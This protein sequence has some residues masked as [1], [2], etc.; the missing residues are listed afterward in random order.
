MDARHLRSRAEHALLGHGQSL[1][2]DYDGSVRPGDDL[3]TSCVL[4]L[5]PD[6]GALKWYFQ[7]SPHDFMTTMPYR[8]LSWWM[9]PSRAA[10]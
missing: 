4:A 3:Y 7:Y 8:R 6:T 10:A 9:Q 5:D 1:A 2:P